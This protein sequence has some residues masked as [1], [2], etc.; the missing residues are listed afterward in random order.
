MTSSPAGS[1]LCHP[2]CCGDDLQT[3]AYNFDRMIQTIG[4]SAASG[5]KSVFWNLDV[6]SICHQHFKTGAF[7]IKTYISTSLELS[8]DLALLDLHTVRTEHWAKVEWWLPL[9][10]G[11]NSLVSPS[12]PHRL[13]GPTLAPLSYLPASYV[14]WAV[15]GSR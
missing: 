11:L 9:H 3:L 1:L 12:P 7:H 10:A 13:A 2:F 8:R 15:T 4:V 6:F 5:T 14:I